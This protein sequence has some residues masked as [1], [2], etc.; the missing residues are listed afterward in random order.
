MNRRAEEIVR[1]A[2][3]QKGAARLG[4]FRVKEAGDY[5]DSVDCVSYDF[6][7]EA[8]TFIQVAKPFELRRTPHDGK[9]INGVTYTHITNVKRRAEKGDISETQIITP[10]Y[11]FDHPILACRDMEGGTGVTV[12]GKA[13][14]WEELPGRQWAAE[15]PD[16]QVAASPEAGLVI[17]GGLQNNFRAERDPGVGD[18]RDHGYAAGSLWINILTARM[19]FCVN[20][21]TNAALWGQAAGE[22]GA[23]TGARYIVQEVHADLSAEQSLGLLTTGLLKNTVADAVGVLSTA[24]AGTDYTAPSHTHGLTDISDVTASATEVNYTDGVT[25]AIQTQLDALAGAT[26]IPRGEFS[27]DFFTGDTPMAVT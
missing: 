22:S 11:Y 1:L 20:P 3:T 27:F 18:D 26:N 5:P 17:A 4:R 13:V 15:A 21:A 14:V 23:P 8:T 24:V 10:P 12:D 19:F 16:S 6:D 9:T 2:I 25:S 7:V